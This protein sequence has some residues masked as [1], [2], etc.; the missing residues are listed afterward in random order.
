M[1]EFGVKLKRIGAGFGCEVMRKMRGADVPPPGA[2]L[3]TVIVTLAATAKS[4]DDTG[5]VS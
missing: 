3:R 1:V 5:I 2:G 4:A